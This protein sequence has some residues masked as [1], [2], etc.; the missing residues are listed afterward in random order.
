MAL[1]VAQMGVPE[2]AV[3]SSGDSFEYLQ[4]GIAVN[5]GSP[6]STVWSGAA[7]GIFVPI[8]LTQRRTYVRAWWSNGTAVAGNIDLGVYTI[9]GATGTKLQSTGAT[10]QAGASTLQTVTISWT[11]DPG[12]YYL[13]ISSSDA[14]TATTFRSSAAA[15]YARNTGCFQ[16]ATQ[17]PLATPVTVVAYAQTG[18]PFF[19]L[20]EQAVF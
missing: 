19:G 20:A 18:M 15:V 2:G 8:R 10:L 11:F 5:A 1:S 3:V 7:V 6:A 16:A 9:S 17:S 13:A 14:T 4:S 12:L